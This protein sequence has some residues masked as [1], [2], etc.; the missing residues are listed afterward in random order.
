MTKVIGIL[1]LKGGVGKT[2]VVS[3]LGDALS[4]CGKK[5]LLVEA[6]FSAPNLG[7]H[8]NIINP[9]VTLH[10]VLS[11]TANIKDAIHHLDRLDIL[12][13]SLF[14]DMQIN[15]LALKDKLNQ[16]RRSYDFILIDSAP[17][18]N[19]DALS[20][21]L[22]S[23]SL[24]FVT[25][26]DHPTLSSTLKSIK[27]ARERGAVIDGLI[28][29]KVHNEDFELSIN[30]IE[31]TIEAPVLAVIPYNVEVLRALSK[32]IPFT[33]HKPK[34]EGSIEYKKLAGVF[35]GQKYKTF[36]LKNIFRL[37]PKPQDVNRELFY[38]RVFKE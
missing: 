20:V 3:S 38:N 8:W 34:S 19:E 22:A 24:I 27:L 29:N 28:L 35:T 23:T 33:T 9:F 5:V 14:P 11:R 26:P 1:S 36:S 10:H 21:I 25:T 6:N 30:D 37:A 12:P 13:S 16:V 15:P 4:G 17:A 7:L 18:I 32:F 31:K 2:S